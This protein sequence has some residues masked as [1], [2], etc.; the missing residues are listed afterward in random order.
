MENNIVKTIISATA[1]T[2]IAVANPLE[3]TSV[4]N[5]PKVSSSSPTSSFEDLLKNGGTF[6]KNSDN[7]YIQKAKIYGRVQIQGGTVLTD[8]E[9][10]GFAELRR[11][12]LGTEIQF[13][14]HFKFKGNADLENGSVNDIELDSLPDSMT[15]PYRLTSSIFS[16]STDLTSSP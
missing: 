3:A 14:Q 9:E 13:L 15:Q 1:L 12:R 4:A 11:T 16:T 10:F 8:G 7:P 2:S 5:A 6:Y